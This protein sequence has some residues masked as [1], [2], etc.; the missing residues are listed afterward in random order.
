MENIQKLRLFYRLKSI[1]RACTVAQRKESPAEHTWSC[2]ILADYFLSRMNM[3]LDRLKVYEL[4][5]YHDVVEIEAGDANLIDVEKRKQKQQL[6]KKAAQ[7]LK[8]SFP[9]PSNTKFIM[10]FAEFEEGKTMEAKFAKAIDALDAEIH[11]L[12]YK[13]D[14]KGWTEKFLREKKEPL[15]N[16]FPELKQTFEEIMNYTK[17][18][19]YF[20]Q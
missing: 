16:G 3:T 13:E 20:E 10:L 15:F 5:L 19:G 6:E 4:L 18:K 14:W 17:E 1:E 9:F 8:Q 2:L 7:K 12:D 11:E